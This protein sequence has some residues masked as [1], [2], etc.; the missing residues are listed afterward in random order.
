MAQRTAVPSLAL[1]LLVASVSSACGLTSNQKQ[2]VTAFGNGASAFGSTVE[3]VAPK[4]ADSIDMLRE[5][6]ITYPS[7][8]SKRAF[9]VEA[10][11]LPNYIYNPNEHKH[12][13]VVVALADALNQYGQALMDLANYGDSDARLQKFSDIAG[14]LDSIFRD[15]IATATAQA[16]GQTLGFAASQVSEAVKKRDLKAVVRAADP[17]VKAAAALLQAEFEGKTAG[18]LFFAY[19]SEIK[20][21][22]DRTKGSVDE[23]TE[24]LM[25]AALKS[26][27]GCGLPEYEQRRQVVAVQRTIVR[28]QGAFSSL[29]A[30]AL[31]ATKKLVA[32]QDQLLQT[33]DHDSTTWQDIGDFV[34]SA[35]KLYA[36]F[37]SSN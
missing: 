37:K 20:V 6:M 18:T 8:A 30:A 4:A 31:T 13:D 7:K 16:V 32:A 26:E 23:S 3:S 34:S 15:P 22:V 19:G 36:A 29:Q 2:A 33:L 28:Q 25:N 12:V 35:S 24:P 9:G 14:S 5:G 21:Y 27:A 11:D 10:T 17:G 1:G